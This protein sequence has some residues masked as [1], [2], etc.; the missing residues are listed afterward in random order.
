MIHA[1]PFCGNVYIGIPWVL[2][3]P[4]FITVNKD[5]VV[6]CLVSAIPLFSLVLF[7]LFLVYFSLVCALVCFLAM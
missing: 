3:H 1:L 4:G 5:P 6:F 7:S 2:S